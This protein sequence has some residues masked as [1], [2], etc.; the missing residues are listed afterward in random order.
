MMSKNRLLILLF[1]GLFFV[2]GCEKVGDDPNPID[3]RS[4]YTGDWV[5]TE[6]NLKS[7][8]ATY[9]VKISIDGTNSSQV[10]LS[11]Y[12][13]LG[14]SVQVSAV[15][16][17]TSITIPVQTVDSWTVAGTGTL[18]A[19]GEIQWSRCSANQLAVRAVYRRQ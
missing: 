8:D 6:S 18:V 7:T 19:E 13:N 17:E 12:M 11:N 16:T 4:D 1:G 10:V 5:V 15:V 2:A 9:T 14:S 3:I